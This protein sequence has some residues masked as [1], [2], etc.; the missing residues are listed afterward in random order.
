MK[1]H[2]NLQGVDVLSSVLKLLKSTSYTKIV[3]R[4]SM[5]QHISVDK[6]VFHI[7]A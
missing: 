3:K 6:P 2:L 4:N 7:V 1:C 5:Q